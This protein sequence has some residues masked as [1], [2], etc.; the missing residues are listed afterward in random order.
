[1]KK[2]RRSSYYKV[3]LT[4][5]RKL[6][7]D[8]LDVALKKHY[9]KGFIELDVTD[10]RRSIRTYRRRRQCRLSFLAFFISCLTRSLSENRSL[11]AGLKKNN[12]IIFDDIDV[13]VAVEMDLH[14]EKVPR[15]IVIRRAQ[16]KSVQ[17]IHDEI[18]KARKLEAQGDS[19]RDAFI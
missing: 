6:I 7:I 8:G 16:N 18:E 1:M 12:I 10:A 19:A 15:L 11:N 4:P 5:F 2:T 13:S 3:P 14:G 17:E 9:M